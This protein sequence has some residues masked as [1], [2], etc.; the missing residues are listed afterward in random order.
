MNKK[1]YRNDYYHT[2][3]TKEKE[4]KQEYKP[5]KIY[6][7]KLNPK[8]EQYEYTEKYINH[9]LNWENE[10]ELIKTQIGERIKL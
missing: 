7:R 9:K 3:P 2:K 5:T 6:E 10:Q 1:R 8:T 4:E